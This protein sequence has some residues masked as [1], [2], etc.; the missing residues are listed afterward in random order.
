MA[1]LCQQ[2]Q[3]LERLNTVV[4]VVSFGRSELARVWLAETNAPFT[5]L[6]D[7]ERVAYQAYGLERSLW[8]AWGW[9]TWVR[10][11]QLL[12]AGRKWRGIQGD[13]G[14]LGGDVI[15]DA[16]GIVRLVYRSADPTDRPAVTQL[17][18]VLRR[19]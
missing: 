19:C 12:L 16:A 7:A 11:T 9:K 3:L 1:Q 4:V 18:A 14:Q 15:V 2:Q 13:S 5:L 6:L 8:R 10:Y 17:L